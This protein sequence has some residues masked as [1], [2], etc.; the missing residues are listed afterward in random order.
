[1]TYMDSCL[2]GLSRGSAVFSP[3]LLCQF[4]I[5]LSN[6]MTEKMSLLKR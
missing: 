5:Y 6:W 2:L 4:Q 1:M 3:V